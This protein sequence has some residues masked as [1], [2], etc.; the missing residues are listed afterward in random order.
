MWLSPVHGV[1][2][3]LPQMLTATCSHTLPR[4]PMRP[5]FLGGSPNFSSHVALLGD[6][7]QDTLSIL[8]SLPAPR[9]SLGTIG[10]LT[11]FRL[12][13]SWRESRGLPW[14]GADAPS[15]QAPSRG[16]GPDQRDP[17]LRIGGGLG[18]NVNMR[19]FLNFFQPW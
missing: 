19:I 14:W 11:G 9:L 6:P 2:G 5:R 15:S 1:W 4:G 8:G 13:G 10:G 18:K 7:G 3:D 17:A 12:V 16:T